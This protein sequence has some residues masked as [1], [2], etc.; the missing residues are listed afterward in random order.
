MFNDMI[1][2]DDV[3]WFLVL[4]WYYNYKFFFEFKYKDIFQFE[5]EF[6]FMLWGVLEMKGDIL[7]VMII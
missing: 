2:V 5:F 7:F 6:V 3:V 1:C 4:L